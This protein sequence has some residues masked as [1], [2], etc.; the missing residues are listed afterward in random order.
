MLH[1]LG[2]MYLIGLRGIDLKFCIFVKKKTLS[3]S[4][5]FENFENFEVFEVFAHLR[6][7]ALCI[8]FFYIPLQPIITKISI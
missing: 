2:G 4:A 3:E 1:P 8:F 7:A 5:F 6:N